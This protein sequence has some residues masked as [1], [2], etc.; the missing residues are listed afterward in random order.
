MGA[1]G[2]PQDRS[3]Q[4]TRLCRPPE[5]Y[6]DD[7]TSRSYTTSSRVRQIQAQMAERALELLDLRQPSFVLDVGCGS[8]LSGELLTAAEPSHTWVGLDISASMLAVAR[9]TRDVEGDM[10][11]GDMGQGLP[12]RPGSF[13]AAMS[14]SAIQWLCNAESSDERD[15]PERRLRRFF[16][17]LYVALRRG[18]RAVFQF[19]PRNKA[20]RDMI[21]GAAIKAGFGVGLLEDD[22]GTK[23]AKLYLVCSVGG[24]DVTGIVRGMDGVEVEDGRRSHGA[25][26][27]KAGGEVKGSRQWIE[28]KKEQ[29]QRK[30][31]VV[32]ASSKYT[33]RRRKP[34]W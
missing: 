31:K 30:G 10:L 33:G 34:A 17:T 32:K 12:F 5:L 14:I 29:M 21:S 3:Q 18:A 9:L 2:P 15:A 23:N 16:D 19:Y 11:L 26:G 25:A 13:D 1:F 20:Q 24:G 22:G 28:R 7:Q 6:Y 27:S 8:G 4:L